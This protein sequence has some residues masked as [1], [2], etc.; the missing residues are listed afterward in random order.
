MITNIGISPAFVSVAHMKSGTIFVNHSLDQYLPTDYRNNNFPAV[1]MRGDQ[2]V[3]II[4][5]NSVQY[6]KH[7]GVRY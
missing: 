6:I 3:V 5:S 7:T 2:T 4:Q 1:P